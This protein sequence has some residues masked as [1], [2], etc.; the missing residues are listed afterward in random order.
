LSS[1]FFL[2]LAG[3]AVKRGK[4]APKSFPAIIGD[5]AGNLALISEMVRGTEKVGFRGQGAGCGNFGSACHWSNWT[6]FWCGGQGAF[7]GWLR[8]FRLRYCLT[9]RDLADA[10]PRSRGGN[11][12][13]FKAELEFSHQFPP[14]SPPLHVAAGYKLGVPIKGRRGL[15]I[16]HGRRFSLYLFLR[17][18]RAAVSKSGGGGKEFLEASVTRELLNDA[19]G[20]HSFTGRQK[21]S[22]S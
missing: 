20:W 5:L 3:G 12:C 8:G 17:P 18:A 15:G 14:K 2:R 9:K 7:R 13:R 1:I 6:D 19:S 11:D 22:Q 4:D 16:R 21:I 10:S